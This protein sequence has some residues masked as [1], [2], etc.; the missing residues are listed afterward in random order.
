MKRI[1][2]GREGAFAVLLLGLG[3]PGMATA[4]EGPDPARMDRIW[5]ATFDRL[6]VQTDIWF[7]QGDFPRTV[8]GL[9]Y[10]VAL[11]PSDYENVT[12]LGWMLE[13]INQ[14]DDA[15]AVYQK[16]KTDNPQNPDSPYPEA[17][18]YFMRKQYEKI[19]SLLEPTL[20]QGPHA[21]TFRV[22][23]HTYERL[24][25][26]EDSIRVWEAY[27]KL[28]PG[29]GAAPANLARVKQKLSQRVGG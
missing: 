21:N 18:L 28:M 25:R 24:E 7:E 13:N 10:V 22:L 4:P 14:Y 1:G 8:E 5:E 2:F 6:A 26:L 19:P 3:L 11:D 23:A 29:D 15:L 16:F 9:R 12:N 20:P 17:Y 27:I